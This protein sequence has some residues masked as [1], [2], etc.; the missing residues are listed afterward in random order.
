[1]KKI[2]FFLILI[3][4][5]YSCKT[6]K[7]Y[8]ERGNPDRSLQDAVK[9]LCKSADD[10]KA[11]EALPVLY[12]NIKASRLEKIKMYSAS[13][14]LARWDK[15]INEYQGL[16][17][18]YNSIM[19]CPAAFKVVVPQSYNDNII[20]TNNLAAQEYYDY[21]QSYFV[22]SGKDN[23]KIAY[24]YFDKTNKYI[25]E[26][27]DVKEKMA[28]AFKNAIVLVVVN[29]VEDGSYFNNNGWGNYGANY[30]NDYF[31]QKLLRDLN[32]ASNRYPA[33]FY[34]DWEVKRD[35]IKADWVVFLRLRDL[36]IPPPEYSYATKNE[37]ANI[38]IGK[39][40]T[41]KPIYKTVY[42]TVK[43][44]KAFFTARGDM[45]VNIRDLFSGRDISYRSCKE[46]FSWG[47]EKATYSGDSQA[48]STRDVE[49]INHTV[50]PPRKEEVLNELYRKIYPEVL[51]NIINAVSF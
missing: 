21:A 3:I 38:K 40:S 7:G 5:A 45:E 30:S 29:Q 24:I 15:I 34:T 4:G 17:N 10:E 28:Q 27:K 48:L 18:A 47:E 46:E 39:D 1:M 8:L 9:K 43:I 32:A 31:Q 33:L 20:E 25:F 2:F 14:D 51:N 13:K 19:A 37:S 35:N 50:T 11:I 22:K 36:Y 16:Q 49:L 41:G 42:A 23:A 6:S 44:T 12:A 26:F